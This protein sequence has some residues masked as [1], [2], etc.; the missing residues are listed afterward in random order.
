M[1][2]K[3]VLSKFG[4]AVRE[5]REEQKWEVT[6]PEHDYELG[7]L[8]FALRSG[9]YGW[10][11]VPGSKKVVLINADQ[12]ENKIS[13]TSV[14]SAW[15]GT[16]HSEWEYWLAGYFV[17]QVVEALM[18]KENEADISMMFDRDLTASGG[19]RLTKAQIW[20]RLSKYFD[21][22]EEDDDEIRVSARI[23]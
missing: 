14:A 10:E 6:E 15:R 16:G 5:Q 21:I 11:R 23:A 8:G 20:E 9:D 7:E 17:V 2:F 1:R 3:N 12:C 22:V 18:N 4:K 13:V 19:R